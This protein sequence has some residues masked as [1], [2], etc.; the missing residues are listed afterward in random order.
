MTAPGSVMVWAVSFEHAQG[1]WGRYKLAGVLWKDCGRGQNKVWFCPYFLHCMTFG[2]IYHLNC[3]V[4]S[5]NK[6]ASGSCQSGG[7]KWIWSG[8][9]GDQRSCEISILED[10]SM[11][12]G[13]CPRQQSWWPCFNHREDLD[14]LK[15]SLPPDPMKVC[16]MTGREKCGCK[17]TLP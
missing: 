15:E 17:I 13:C 4:V 12:S 5:P 8:E 10:I 2:K 3:V 9:R 1:L 14:I 11:G 16:R 6:E 7:H